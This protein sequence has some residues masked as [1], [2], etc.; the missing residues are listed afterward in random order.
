MTARDY[1]DYLRSQRSTTAHEAAENEKARDAERGT[2]AP[3]SAT[4][5]TTYGESAH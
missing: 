1:A 2:Y 5:H 3:R 4:V